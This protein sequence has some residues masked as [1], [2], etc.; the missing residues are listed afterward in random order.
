MS[1]LVNA[2]WS[3]RLGALSANPQ[4]YSIVGIVIGQTDSTTSTDLHRTTQHI[5]D[6]K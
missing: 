5:F 2:V 6:D 4:Y 1:S 3:D